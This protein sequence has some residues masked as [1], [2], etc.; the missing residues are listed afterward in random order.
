M[1]THV[2]W[3]GTIKR[4]NGM[5]KPVLD[6][7]YLQDKYIATMFKEGDR[8]V[9]VT[10]KYYPKRSTGKRHEKGNQNGYLWAVVLP[11][12][13][14]YHGEYDADTMLYHLEGKFC[15]TQKEIEGTATIKRMKKM[16]TKEFSDT[17]E[18]LRDYYL[19][20]YEV[21]IPEPDKNWQAKPASESEKRKALEAAKERRLQNEK[22]VE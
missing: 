5:L 11:I 12:I 18:R 21:W 4:V 8:I 20:E 10:K 19:I 3:Q 1:S 15:R 2:H 17:I 9:Q 13:C 16:N 6:Q 22:G 7:P 14:E